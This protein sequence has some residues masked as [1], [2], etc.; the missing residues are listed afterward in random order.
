MEQKSCGVAVRVK[1]KIKHMAK[2]CD[3]ITR[4]KAVNGSVALFVVR[5]SKYF[6]ILMSLVGCNQSLIQKDL[7]LDPQLTPYAKEFVTTSEAYGHPLVIDNLSMHFGTN[8]GPDILGECWA[9]NKGINGTPTV[10][11]SSELWPDLSEIERKAVVFHE[12]GHCVLWLEHDEN[13]IRIG[14]DY[15]TR[16]IMYPYIQP[17]II[18]LNYW[19]YYMNELFNGP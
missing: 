14:P 19:N 3:F 10:L 4:I 13:W 11:I 1:N 9:K 2:T 15:I 17:E 12:L 8:L 7:S 6:F 5:R 18:Y 16:S